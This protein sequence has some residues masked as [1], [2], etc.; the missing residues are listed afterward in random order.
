MIRKQQAA[1]NWKEISSGRI[2]IYGRPGARLLT[3][4]RKAGCT[5]VVTLLAEKEGAQEIGSRACQMGMTWLWFPLPNATPPTGEL[6]AE[7]L[8]MIGRLL[9][10]LDEG[11]TIFI[12]CSAGIHRT[13]MIVYALLRQRGFSA[14]S[15]KE[16]LISLRPET[17]MGMRQIHFTWGDSIVSGPTHL[18]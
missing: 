1:I 10:L 13:G 9:C 2:A 15:A 7:S 12:H 16:M 5:R 14:A 17:V 8:K 6:R 4:L 11:E 18:N 3:A